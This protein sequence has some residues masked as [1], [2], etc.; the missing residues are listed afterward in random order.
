MYIVII[1]YM[2][3]TC[4]TYVYMHMSLLIPYYHFVMNYNI[5]VEEKKFTQVNWLHK[6]KEIVNERSHI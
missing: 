3:Y 1:L 4:I 6:I 2:L 5:L